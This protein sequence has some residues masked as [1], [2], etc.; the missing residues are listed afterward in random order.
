MQILRIA[1]SSCYANRVRSI[2]CASHQIRDGF[3]GFRFDLVKTFPHATRFSWKLTV[4]RKAFVPIQHALV[5][6]R[7]EAFP[8]SASARPACVNFRVTHLER[9]ECHRRSQ[10]EE[11]VCL[12]ELAG[13]NLPT[14]SLCHSGC[15]FRAV[16]FAPN[17]YRCFSRLTNT[18]VRLGPAPSFG[19]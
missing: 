1:P 6:S 9:L 15:S 11:T 16:V 4:H 3:I 2:Q 18:D 7:N 14:N 8:D 13:V 10:N 19:I 5:E 17:E 12:L